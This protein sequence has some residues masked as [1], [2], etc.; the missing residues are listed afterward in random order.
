[1]TVTCGRLEAQMTGNPKAVS[2]RPFN[3]GVVV[4]GKWP[5]SEGDDATLQKFGNV[6]M[7]QWGLIT[8]YNGVRMRTPAPPR[9]ADWRADM[10]QNCPNAA[11]LIIL[12][13]RNEAFFSAPS[14][15]FLCS[16]RGG[17]EVVSAV[18]RTLQRGYSLGD[19]IRA[20]ISTV[21][22]LLEQTWPLSL[23]EPLAVRERRNEFEMREWQQKF[24]KSDTAWMIIERGFLLFLVLI[25]VCVMGG[26][27]TAALAP[28]IPELRKAG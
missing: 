20:G 19:A 24:Q 26:M 5:Q 27:A 3:L 23:E 17:P 12:A 13:D 7:A 18:E 28:A 9:A 16:Q 10:D 1:M 15:E 8:S 6:L 4:I 22:T 25:A 21:R 11:L 2:T 14:C